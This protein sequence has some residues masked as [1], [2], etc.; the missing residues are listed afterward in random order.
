MIM[1]GATR[2]SDIFHALWFMQSGGIAGTS[3]DVA[4]YPLDTI[5]TR[6]QSSQGKPWALVWLLHSS[7]LLTN[8]NRTIP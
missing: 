7:A 2:S 3:V 6:L 5:K 8:H 4:L 1:Q